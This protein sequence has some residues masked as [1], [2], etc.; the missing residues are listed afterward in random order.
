MIEGCP[1]SQKFKKPHPEEIKCHFC[2]ESV[3]IWTDEFDTNCPKCGKNVSRNTQSCLD[4]CKAARECVGDEVYNRYMSS[5]K[6]G[7]GK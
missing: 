4:W 6:K 2:G 7:D 3:E 1:G 5:K